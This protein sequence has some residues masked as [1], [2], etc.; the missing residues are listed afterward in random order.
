[1]PVA[2]PSPPPMRFAVDAWSAWAPGLADSDA[3]RAWARAPWRPA[4]DE[5]PELPQYPMMLRR[6]AERL[7]RMA[8]QTVSEVRGAAPCPMVWASHRGET[9][10]AVPLL[11]DLAE[12]GAV[13][14][15]PFSLSVHNAVS[16]LESI[17]H[18]DTGNYTALAAAGESAEL[19][20]VEALGP[21]RRRTRRS[22]RHRVRRDRARLLSPL[23][24]RRRRAV[25]VVVAAAAG[26]RGSGLRAWLGRWGTGHGA[27]GTGG[28]LAGRGC[29]SG[30]RF[31]RA[32]PTLRGPTR[33]PCP[34]PRAPHRPPTRP[35]RPR[36][37]SLR[38]RHPEP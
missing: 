36:L 7:A 30:P 29:R 4:G 23:C 21:A 38:R 11:R 1:M 26:G 14:P 20:V 35:A 25:R 37:L 10:R 18:G 8:L 15:G 33:A 24:G 32:G 6:R 9:Q 5:R 34:V 28:R 22:H 17:A 3:W 2:Y 12:T 19:A 31:R 27:R 16:A 13:A